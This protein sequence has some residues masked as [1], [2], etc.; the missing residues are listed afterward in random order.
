MLK[1]LLIICLFCTSIV[2]NAN[3]KVAKINKVKHDPTA[4]DEFVVYNKGKLKA[5]VI[6]GSDPKN[7]PMTKT[8]KLID[9]YCQDFESLPPGAKELCLQKDIVT[10][11]FRT[12]R[13]LWINN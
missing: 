5:Y 1:T 13:N 7:C 8:S 10:T 6:Y 11:E 12:T 2:S 9:S 3:S 4:C